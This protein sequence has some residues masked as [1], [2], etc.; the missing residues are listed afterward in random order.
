MSERD[1]AAVLDEHVRAEFVD[2]DPDAA[3]A[4]MCADATLLHVP[5][6]TG[7]R[8]TEALRRFYA[9]VF[10]PS[11]PADTEVRMVSRTV[12]PGRVV[13]ELV[14]RA[15]HDRVMRSVLPGVAPTDRRFELPHVAVVDFRDGRIAAER[16]YWDQASLLVQ[17]GLLPAESVPVLGIAQTRAYEDPTYP[18]NEII[19]DH[20]RKATER[21]GI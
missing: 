9:D 14:V 5:V 16:I 6:G 11:W 7:A 17:L 20:E 1:L 21:N 12:G 18:L 15:T 4:T 8:G 13:D 2:R 10:M 19:T 3:V